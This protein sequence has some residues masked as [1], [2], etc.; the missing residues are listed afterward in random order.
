MYKRLYWRT[1]FASLSAK[2]REVGGFTGAIFPKR[3][4]SDFSE[5]VLQSGYAKRLYEAVFDNYL[6]C[7]D[8]WA[9]VAFIEGPLCD[10]GQ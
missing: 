5:A 2:R 4:A 3:F 7:G 8:F 6:D 9:V 1:I 10:V